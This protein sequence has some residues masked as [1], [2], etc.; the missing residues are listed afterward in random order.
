MELITIKK[1]EYFNLLT[2]QVQMQ[3]L[4]AAGIDNAS[5]YEYART[6]LEEDGYESYEEVA[7]EMINGPKI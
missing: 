7:A 5:A 2:I 3:Y 1:E 6:L 4:D